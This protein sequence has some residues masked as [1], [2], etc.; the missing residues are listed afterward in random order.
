M[1]HPPNS[2]QVTGGGLFQG[3][4]L[5]A[6]LGVST[7]SWFQRNSPSWLSWLWSSSSR[8]GCGSYVGMLT[9]A[10]GVLSSNDCAQGWSVDRYMPIVSLDALP[11]TFAQACAQYGLAG[12]TAL[13]STNFAAK[14]ETAAWGSDGTS[15][16]RQLKFCDPGK[17]MQW[18]DAQNAATMWDTQAGVTN[19]YNATPWSELTEWRRTL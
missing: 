14:A 2:L 18:I 4:G 12:M 13:A 16:Y 10:A 7:P 6:T 1:H 9:E 3:Y 19:Q 5:D 17:M 8:I 11:S 15:P